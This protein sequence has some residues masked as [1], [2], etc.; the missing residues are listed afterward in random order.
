MAQGEHDAK[1]LGKAG[2][3][4]AHVCSSGGT[5]VVGP[6]RDAVV[7]DRETEAVEK[8]DDFG[9]VHG[10]IEVEARGRDIRREDDVDDLCAVTEGD[11]AV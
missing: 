8:S 4:P 2:I 7:I 5:A 9:L 11:L 6:Y 3:S 1:A 10:L